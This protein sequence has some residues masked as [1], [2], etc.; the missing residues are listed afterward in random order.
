MSVAIEALGWLALAAGAFFSV[1][2]CIGLARLPDFFTRLH[3]ASVTDTLGAGLI[4]LGLML[5]AGLT[6]VTV[7]LAIIGLLV[8]FTSPTATHALA[9]AALTRGLRPLAAGE[10]PP[11]SK[12]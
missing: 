8:L 6:L 4:L 1:A 7:K 12:P 11:P 9:K 3:G 2:G 5:H 10:E